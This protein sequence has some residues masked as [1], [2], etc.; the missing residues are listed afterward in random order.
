MV[1][2]PKHLYAAWNLVVTQVKWEE[3][4]TKTTKLE[5]W[6]YGSVSKAC[7]ANMRTSIC[8]PTRKLGVVALAYN[9]VTGKVETGRSLG[10]YWPAESVSSRF[11]ESPC[12][13]N[14]TEKNRIHLALTSDCMPKCTP[15]NI[16]TLIYKHINNQGWKILTSNSLY[17]VVLAHKKY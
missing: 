15:E 7:C 12:L 11:T 8:I 6:E 17:S 3:D 16:Y 13:K 5:C 14:K 2:A 9:S 1:P 10:L 4:S